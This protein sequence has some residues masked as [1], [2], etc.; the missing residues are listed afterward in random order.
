[1]RRA[2]P[3]PPLLV[4]T[5]IAEHF[6][7]EAENFDEKVELAVEAGADAFEIRTLL[8]LAATSRLRALTAAQAAAPYC[9]PR[10]SAVEVAPMTPE[11]QSR[12]SDRL[13]AMSEDQ[14]AGYLR[15][16]ARGI[17]TIE[18]LESAP[19]GDVNEVQLDMGDVIVG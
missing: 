19:L 17:L 18:H 11:T 4:M 8:D 13:E 12:F 3:R 1:M 9:S 2:Q 5:M 16:I 10:L 14:I 15:Q 6:L 7:S